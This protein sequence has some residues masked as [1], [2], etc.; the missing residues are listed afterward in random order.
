MTKEQNPEAV[1]GFQRFQSFFKTPRGIAAALLCSTVFLTSLVYLITTTKILHVGLEILRAPTMLLLNLLPVLLLLLLLFFLTRKLFFSISSVGVFLIFFAVADRIKVSMRQEPLLPTDLTLVKEVTAILKTFPVYQLILIGVLLLLFIGL[2]IVSFLKSSATPLPLLPRLAGIVL[3]LVCG[4][5]A[6]QL[7]YTDK[8]LY[9]SY[10]TVDNPYFQVNQYNTRGMIYSF[11]HQFNITQ[12][13]AP[14]GYD[15]NVFAAQEKIEWAAPEF[16]PEEGQ[17]YPHIVMIMGEA[18]SDLSE[19][20]HL[21]FTGYR[22]PLENW[23]KICA[24][25]GTVSGHIVV[26]NFGGGTSNT[27]YDVLTGCATRYLDSPLPSYNFIHDDMDA[28]PRQLSMLGYETLSIHPGYAWFYNRQN[29]YPDLGFETCYFLEDSFDLATQG[30]GGYINET[31]TMDKII[32]TLDTHIKETDTPL[33]SFTV[34]I[35]NH[36]PYE[37][38]YGTLPQ[39]F[40]SDVPLDE[41]Q[42]DLLTQY[43]QGIC[44]AD[45]EIGRL[46]AYAEQSEEPIVLVYFGDHLPGFSNG[47]EFFDLLEYPIDANGTLQEQL[48]VYETPYF[49]WAND[50]AKALPST[51]T[52]A[53][54]DLPEN[55]RISSQFL[56]AALLD[57]V[58]LDYESPLFAYDNDLRKKLPVCA[59]NIYVD[60]EGNYTD[61][62][63]AEEMESVTHLQQW[64]YYKLFDET[65]P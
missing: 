8:A 42:T 30:Y 13:K 50:A 46:K 21:D 56:G 41:T 61:T 3:V 22:D 1:S 6:N 62:I 28:L 33:F 51:R 31:A 55:G 26:P 2:L 47:M 24:E 4:F 45:E 58:V 36:G 19:N 23:K 16:T 17:P 40:T 18:F 20:E 54:I 15:P 37:N 14:E 59:K 52:A 44:D 38:K 27:E 32:E 5:G 43:F 53:D 25:E 12:M 57:L 34:T 39:N 29:V 48:A 49:I 35:Q 7:W 10:P 64:Q 63:S 9:D 11:L 65:L 60:I